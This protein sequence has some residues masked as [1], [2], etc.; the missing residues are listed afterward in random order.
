M[1]IYSL[2]HIP[3]IF[4]SMSILTPPSLL[5]SYSFTFLQVNIQTR[6]LLDN[7]PFSHLLLEPKWSCF[8]SFSL[9]QQLTEEEQRREEEVLG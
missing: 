2:L 9:L 5:F 8:V 3:P 4:V 7:F 6:I 1:N